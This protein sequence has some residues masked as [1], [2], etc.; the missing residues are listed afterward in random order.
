MSS[1]NFK[2]NVRLKSFN[3]GRSCPNVLFCS[4]QQITKIYDAAMKLQRETKT[5]SAL[6][7]GK[8][9]SMYVNNNVDPL[10]KLCA[11]YKTNTTQAYTAANNALNHARQAHLAALA[12]TGKITLLSANINKLQTINTDQLDKLLSNIFSVRKSYSSLGLQTGI[13]RLKI[14]S[15][16]Q[17]TKMTNY[18]A[19]NLNLRMKINAYKS[20][21][22]SISQMSC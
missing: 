15:A 16:E 1:Y 7:Q 12:T 14:A 20:V 22:N 2:Q 18:R 6:V 21:Y 10:L 11:D 19:K 13:T 17:V 8:E 3:W 5:A 9:I 4:S